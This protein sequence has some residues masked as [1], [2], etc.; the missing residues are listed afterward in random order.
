MPFL[1]GVS[2]RLVLFCHVLV[3]RV[4][5]L[6]CVC[7][8]RAITGYLLVLTRGYCLGGVVLVCC[9]VM[10]AAAW[11][12]SV[13]VF[14]LVWAAVL[15]VAVVVMAVAVGVRVVVLVLVPL[16]VRSWRWRS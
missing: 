15:G 2:P 9:V 5:I 7:H 10:V 3:V 12:C 6:A 1:H 8:V 4:L 11:Y 16:V 13:G 14:L